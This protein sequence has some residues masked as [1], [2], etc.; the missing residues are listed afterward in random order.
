MSFPTPRLARTA[1][2]LACAGLAP[3]A[4]ALTPAEFFA[5]VSP[6]VWQVLTYEKNGAYIAQGSAVV[7]APDTLI[8]NCHV[9]SKAKSFDVIHD[10][11]AYVG[12]LDKWDPARDICQIRTAAPLNAP[13]VSIKATPETRQGWT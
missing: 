13:A 8:T 7:I 10:N 11:L 3:A 12:H 2:L 4:R 9:L 5:K 1:L 6:S